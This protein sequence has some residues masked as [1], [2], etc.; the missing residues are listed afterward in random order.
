M[1]F[2][3]LLCLEGQIQWVR[4][5]QNHPGSMGGGNDREVGDARSSALESEAR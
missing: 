5:L 1:P 2:G 4:A 3:P